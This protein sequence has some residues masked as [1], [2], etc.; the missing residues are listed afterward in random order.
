MHMYASGKKDA[1]DVIRRT[2]DAMQ[3][4]GIHDQ[5]GGGFHRYSTDE[6]WIVPHFEKMAYDNAALLLNYTHGYEI[7]RDEEYRKTASSITGFILS[8]LYGD[9]HFY[10]S[11][12]ADAFPGDDGDYWTWTAKEAASVLN[13][14]EFNVIDLY[15]HL[16]GMPEMKERQRHVLYR[17]MPPSDI[18]SKL[19]LSKERVTEIIENAK[20]RLLIERQ[21]RP[22]PA[23]DR[24]VYASYTGMLSNALLQYS[25]TFQD[26]VA[27]RSAEDA[28]VAYVRNS[29]D[30]EKGFSHSIENKIWGLLDDQVW[31]LHALLSLYSFKQSSYIVDIL[32]RGMELLSNY[33][34]RSG[35][36]SD[37]DRKHGEQNV[38]FASLEQIS[39]YDTPVMSSNAA[40]S[41][42]FLRSAY[43]LEWD[44]NTE[45]AKRIVSSL[46]HQCIA[47]GPY[48]SS[49]FLSLKA[50]L[51][52]PSICHI[53]GS[54]D[55]PTFKELWRTAGTIHS[56]GK[57]LLLIDIESVDADAL[58]PTAANMIELCRNQ[59]KP[60]AFVCRGRSC[61]P[62]VDNAAAL[63]SLLST[64][65]SP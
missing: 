39:I 61:S 53:V 43:M 5:L 6:S 31:M 27:R 47:Q 26:K 46:A 7:F 19:M 40:A 2:L 35:V 62:P 55:D 17:H 44:E 65:T 21:K 33:E 25:L 1:A 48:A 57:E 24:S 23:V 59:G 30:Q 37:C 63:L 42:L 49:L 18:S 22:S 8:T 36:L 10:S 54:P 11:Q 64:E 45:R 28:I 4:G 60:L 9:A 12:D 56:P 20:S 13:E 50:L 14:Q 52:P 32:R 15:F 58:S 16:H 34:F 38:G 41:L 51:E 29:F 3:S